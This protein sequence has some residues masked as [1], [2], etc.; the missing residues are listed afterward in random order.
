MATREL[1]ANELRE[2][3]TQGMMERMSPSKDRNLA[4]DRVV[5]MGL[6]GERLGFSMTFSP[7]GKEC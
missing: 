2:W 1:I 7:G 6:H 5:G 3:A 4:I